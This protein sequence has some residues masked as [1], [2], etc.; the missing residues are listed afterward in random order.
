MTLVTPGQLRDQIRPIT[1]VGTDLFMLLTKFGI[2]LDGLSMIQKD[3]GRATSFIVRDAQRLAWYF[4]NSWVIGLARS[5]SLSIMRKNNFIIIV[6]MFRIWYFC[7]WP[8]SLTDFSGTWSGQN[9]IMVEI[10]QS[11]L[12]LKSVSWKSHFWP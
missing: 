4:W 9:I 11:M 2:K 7:F 3:I 12:E 10:K 1:F 5:T 8:I 6:Y